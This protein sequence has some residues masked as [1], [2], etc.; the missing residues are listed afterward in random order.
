MAKLKDLWDSWD[1]T[2][3]PMR[4]TAK[5]WPD[6][7]YFDIYFLSASG[8][9]NGLHEDGRYDSFLG[10]SGVWELYKEPK[11][12][13]ELWKWIYHSGEGWYWSS[14]DWMTEAKAKAMANG[15]R[16]LVGKDPNCLKP[17]IVEVDE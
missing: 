11:K 7:I 1:K 17:L 6:S 15:G 3:L 14:D 12:T 2:K 13:K 16:T 10:E 4:V 9:F 8:L 5:D